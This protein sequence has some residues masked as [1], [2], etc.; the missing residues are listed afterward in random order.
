M[1]IPPVLSRIE[2]ADQ[3]ARGRQGRYIRPFYRLHIMHPYARLAALVSPP[4]CLRNDA[5]DLVRK[6]SV[7]LTKQAILAAENPAALQRRAMLVA[8]TDECP[9][10]RENSR[11]VW[12]DGAYCGKPL[13]K[14]RPKPA[15]EVLREIAISTRAPASISLIPDDGPDFQSSEECHDFQEAAARHR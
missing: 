4:C 1:I 14:R 11:A 5:I 2:E 10:C 8:N 6:G 9:I 7:V 12:P 3:I 13:V 15:I